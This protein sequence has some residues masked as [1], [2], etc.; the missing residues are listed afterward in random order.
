MLLLQSG[1]E[2]W[3]EC[4]AEEEIRNINI[5]LVLGDYNTVTTQ[6]TLQQH[7][8]STSSNTE[9]TLSPNTEG[10]GRGEGGGNY[11]KS[12]QII[13]LFINPD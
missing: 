6:Q 12:F 5:Y 3:V 9:N 2:A 10:E 13:F 4:R 7:S 1:G 8:H 11:Q